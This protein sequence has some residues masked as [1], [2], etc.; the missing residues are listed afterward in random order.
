MSSLK[1]K[2]KMAVESAK[3]IAENALEG[4]DLKVSEQ[5]F[6]QRM[7]ICQ[8]CDRYKKETN[9]CNECGCFLAIKAKL[10]GMKCPLN[11]WSISIMEEKK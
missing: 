3:I 11:K 10:T 2:L 8:G 5:E 1:D 9:Q 6:N 7:A 4:K